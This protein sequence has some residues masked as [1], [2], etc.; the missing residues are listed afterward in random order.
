DETGVGHRSVEQFQDYLRCCSHA[1]ADAVRG[2][3]HRKAFLKWV[4]VAIVEAGAKSSTRPAGR[5]HSAPTRPSLP[6]EHDKQPLYFLPSFRSRSSQLSFQKR[7]ACF[8]TRQSSSIR[9]RISFA[10]STPGENCASMAISAAPSFR[11]V[12]TSSA[13]CSRVPV[14]SIRSFS[15]GVL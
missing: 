8:A 13:I 14:K 9:A 6:V 1:R 12:V 15:M 10:V 5:A 11:A 4:D 3:R 7:Q 2:G